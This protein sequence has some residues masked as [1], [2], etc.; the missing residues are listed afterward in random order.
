[1]SDSGLIEVAENAELATFVAHVSTSDADGGENGRVRCTLDSLDFRLVEIYAGEYKIVT[2]NLLDREL[3]SQYNVM[4]RCHDLGKP[5]L[6]A[7]KV[8]N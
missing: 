1:M 8:N 3:V 7:N 5:R 6:F 4:V 2:A